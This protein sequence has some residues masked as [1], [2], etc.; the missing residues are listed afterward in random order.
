MN[1]TTR[2][3][4]KISDGADQDPIKGASNGLLSH[5]C[6]EFEPDLGCYTSQDDPRGVAEVYGDRG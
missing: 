1:E 6:R 5:I 3:K 2:Q 4:D